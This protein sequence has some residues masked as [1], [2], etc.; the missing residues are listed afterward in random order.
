MTSPIPSATKRLTAYVPTDLYWW[1][2]EQSKSENR[3]VS[4]YIETM[5][6]TLKSQE[7]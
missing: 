6:R 7:Q 4:N 2:K 3:T 5:I 1:L